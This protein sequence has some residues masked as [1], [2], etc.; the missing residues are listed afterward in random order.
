MGESIQK[1]KFSGEDKNHCPS[2]SACLP[3]YVDKVREAMLRNPCRSARQ[4]SSE[5]GL[6]SMNLRCVL[7]KDLNFNLHNLSVVQELDGNDYEQCLTFDETV[8]N[9]FQENYNLLIIMS[10]EAHF[11][12]TE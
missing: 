3:Q 5:L 10:N 4:H 6:S 7:H 12:P 11:Y 1:Y 8:F 9:M 2:L